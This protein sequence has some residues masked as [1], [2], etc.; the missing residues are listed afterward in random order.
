[1]HK[2]MNMMMVYLVFKGLRL[3]F[4]CCFQEM[5]FYVASGSYTPLQLFYKDFELILEF[6]FIHE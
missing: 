3:W 6:A 2:Y 5:G 1:M 4:K